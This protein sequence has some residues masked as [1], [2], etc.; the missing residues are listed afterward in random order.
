MRRESGLALEPLNLGGNEP[1]LRPSAIT[2]SHPGSRSSWVE[3]LGEPMT[4]MSRPVT[5]DRRCEHQCGHT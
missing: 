2:L 1:S 4:F 3:F 5:Y